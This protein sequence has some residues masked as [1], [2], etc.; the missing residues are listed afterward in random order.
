MASQA[1]AGPLASSGAAGISVSY[2]QGLVAFYQQQYEPALRF[3]EQA[4]KE[5]PWLYEA[6]QLG[7]QVRLAQALDQRD[8]GEHT[9]AEQSFTDAAARL[10][11]AAEIGRSD[12]QVYEALAETYIRWEELDYFQ[13]KDPAAKVKEALLAADRALAA[14]PQESHGHTK[15][16]YAYFFQGSYLQR[17]G[18]PAEALRV[19]EQQLAEGKLATAQHRDDAYAYE[20]LGTAYLRIAEASVEEK[21]RLVAILR[22]RMVVMRLLLK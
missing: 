1:R 6:V 2:V 13:A 10:S 5:A 17:H 22:L 18:N 21:S 15:K 19:R 8:R 20:N 14:S 3:A 16:A 4:H 12:H 11:Q 7:G 9:A